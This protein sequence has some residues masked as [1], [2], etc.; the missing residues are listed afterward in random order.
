MGRVARSSSGVGN[1]HTDSRLVL[2][3]PGS[4]RLG[5]RC[6]S[7]SPQISK[8]FGNSIMHPVGLLGLTDTRASA[9]C[10]RAA[11]GAQILS[12]RILRW[13]DRSLLA[14]LVT[15]PAD[16]PSERSAFKYFSNSNCS[17]LGDYLF[18]RFRVATVCIRARLLRLGSLVFARR[19]ASRRSVEGRRSTSRCAI[20]VKQVVYIGNISQMIHLTRSRKST[21]HKRKHLDSALSVWLHLC[22]RSFNTDTHF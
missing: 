6:C 2:L 17:Q 8:T 14:L 3:V 1:C 10:C 19:I 20:V 5:E 15:P 21:P 11:A 16:Y 13:I 7:R 22:C 4:S 18:G 9:G 12:Q